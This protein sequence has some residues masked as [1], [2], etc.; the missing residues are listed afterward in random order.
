MKFIL[1]KKIGMSQIP[2]KNGK[3]VSATFIKAGPCFITQIKSKEKN[4]YSAVQ[5]GFEEAK[6]LKKPQEGHLKKIKKKLRFLREFRIEDEKYLKNLKVGDII[7]VSIFKEGEKVNI[8][9]KSKGKGFQGVVKRWG[10]KGAPKT[11][12]TKHAHRQPGSIGVAGLQRV[13]K[14]Q[15][16]AGRTGGKTVT[17]KNLEILDVDK[18]NNLLVVKGHVPGANNSLVKIVS[19]SNT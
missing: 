1:G 12:G 11:H 7:D 18:N 19:K 3:M 9:G 13:K 16:M 10:F 2:D 15:K 5:I 4:G 17:I 8:T 14:G 6:K